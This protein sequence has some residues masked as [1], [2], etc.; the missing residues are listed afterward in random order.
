MDALNVATIIIALISFAG[1]LMSN[2][3]SWS[4]RLEGIEDELNLHMQEINV[5]IGIVQESEEIIHHAGDELPNS[6]QIARRLCQKHEEILARSFSE[7]DLNH[8]IKKE[9]LAKLRLRKVKATLNADEW[10]KA[11]GLYRGSVFMLRDL[12]A[13]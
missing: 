5:L 10:K 3:M 7:N 11:F 2:T 9:S 8:D 13:E 1:T 4:K 12:C 6:I